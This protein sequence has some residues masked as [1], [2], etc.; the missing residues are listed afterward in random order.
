MLTGD[1]VLAFVS[2]LASHFV[3]DALPHIETTYYRKPSKSGQIPNKMECWEYWESAVEILLAAVLLYVFANKVNNGIIIWLGGL[4]GIL[5]DLFDNVPWWN[6]W[7][8]SRK[9]FV[10]LHYFHNGIHFDLKKKQL[11]LGYIPPLIVLTFSLL[12]LI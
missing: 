2:G 10:W 6:E 11:W 8:R 1:P 4:G 5:L 7:F 3:L 12:W 9:W